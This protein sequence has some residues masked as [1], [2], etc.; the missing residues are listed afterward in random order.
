MR[1]GLNRS[2]LKTIAL[3]FMVIDHIGLFLPGVF[4]L[5]AHPITRFVAP[6]FAYLMVDGFFYTKSRGKYC[7]RLWIAGILMQ[8]GDVLSFLVFKENGI[9]NNIFLTLAFGFSIIWLFEIAKHEENKGKRIGFRVL[10]IA[11]TIIS[12]VLSFAWI[13]LFFGCDLGVEGGLE[14]IPLILIVYFFYKSKW[15]Q[16]VGIFAYSMLQLFLLYGGIELFSDL[17]MLCINCEWMTF[18]VIP[19]IFLYNG[20]EGKK[21]K[22]GKWFFYVF[23]PLH[24]W[25]IEAVRMMVR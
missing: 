11:L 12:I 8:I 9:Q 14:L 21:S 4:G 2:K 13:R 10:A 25:V 15:K 19:F 22:F 24:L 7:L 18:L 20:E 6:L 16:A 1:L 3:I 5:M 23:Y 17:S